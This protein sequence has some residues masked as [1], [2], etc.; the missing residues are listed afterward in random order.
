MLILSRWSRLAYY[1]LDL[2]GTWGLW[3]LEL[4]VSDPDHPKPAKPSLSEFDESGRYE[5]WVRPFPGP[6]GRWQVSKPRGTL[7]SWS[8][9]CRELFF[10]NLDNPIMVTDYTATA[11]AEDKG[12]VHLTFLL[13]F[14]DELRRRAEQIG[15]HGFGMLAIPS[16][17][18]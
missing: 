15:F 9:N 14:F 6:G 10:Q 7:P 5:V 12:D 13:N 17:T 3:T 18:R 1:E 2:E 4:D 16:P 8:R 11:P